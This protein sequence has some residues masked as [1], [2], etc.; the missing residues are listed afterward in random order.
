M[1]AAPKL[2]VLPRKARVVGQFEVGSE[3]RVL[4]AIE[5][6]Q[7]HACRGLRS[8]SLELGLLGVGEHSG[9]LHRLTQDQRRLGGLRGGERSEVR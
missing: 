3:T 8:E 9:G 7:E 5:E 6:H 1:A 2:C 4:A